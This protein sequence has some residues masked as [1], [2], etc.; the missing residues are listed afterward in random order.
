MR[1]RTPSTRKTASAT[2][3]IVQTVPPGAKE[4]V[5]T[6]PMPAIFIHGLWLH[7]TSWQ[8]WLDYFAD[9]GYDARAPGWPDF[10]DTVAETRQHPDFMI[11]Q[12]IGDVVDHYAYLLRDLPAKP[13][14][15]G[16]SFGGLVAQE[17]LDRDLVAAAIAIDPAPIKGVIPLPLS[18]LRSNLPV[19][20]NPLSVHRAVS[21]TPDE[22]RYS[23]ANTLSDQEAARLYYDYAIPA[24]GRPIWQTAFANVVPHAENKVDVR[25]DRAP[26]LLMAGRAD[27][28]VPPQTTRIVKRLYSRSPAITDLKEWPGRGHSLA[29]DSG[30]RELADYVL[31]WLE[32][33]EV[34]SAA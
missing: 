1:K 33:R 8:P 13:V 17:L 15:I 4:P 11:E 7:A 31:E 5:H 6:A 30:W 26:L 25:K 19:L 28:T 10:P 23:F 34:P 2:V 27:H 12:G 9:A 16:H 14:V 24:P 32:L 29:V 20:R 21:L 18:Q 22:F 3:R